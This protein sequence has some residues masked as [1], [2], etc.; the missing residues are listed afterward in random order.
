MNQSDTLGNSGKNTQHSTTQHT[1]DGQTLDENAS[2]RTPTHQAQ[3]PQGEKQL[4]EPVTPTGSEE[5]RHREEEHIRNGKIVVAM[6]DYVPTCLEELTLKKGDLIYVVDYNP[7]G[8]WAYGL[9]IT[10]QTRGLF[11]KDYVSL[12]QAQKSDQHCESENSGDLDPGTESLSEIDS[13]LPSKVLK[14][15]RV[16]SPDGNPTL[17]NMICERLKV[18]LSPM[19]IEYFSN[20]ECRPIIQESVHGKEVFLVCTADVKRTVNDHLWATLLTISALKRAGA[21]RITLIMP[22]YYYARQDKKD[23]CRAAIS[24]RLFAS[25]LETAGVNHV[26]CLDL[27]SASIQGFFP[28]SIPVENLYAIAPV[29]EYLRS[30][31]LCGENYQ[32]CFIGISPDEGAFKRTRRYAEVLKLKYLCLSKTRDYTRPNFVDTT[33]TE[34]F[35]D[36]SLLKGRWA[37][38][39]DDMCDTFGTVQAASKVLVR[40]GALG[41]FVVVTHGILSGPAIERLNSTP[42]VVRMICSDS[43]PQ[44]ENL[45]KCDKLSVFSAAPLLAEVVRRRLDGESVSKMFGHT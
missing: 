27:H 16:F 36:L 23:S 44:E 22:N 3:E 25:T 2:E 42:E 34:I 28:E 17:A 8:Q 4:R 13:S 7:T 26:I 35:G 21:K 15:V 5:H 19:R 38:I 10:T 1:H 41:V 18:P 24:A 31:L 20:G 12:K 43:L 45:K 32:D 29:A 30:G 14:K 40:A 9:C 11:R 37:I 6:C 33:K 39:F